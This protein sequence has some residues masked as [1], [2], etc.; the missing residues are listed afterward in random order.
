MSKIAGSFAC[1]KV[2]ARD[3]HVWMT[4]TTHLDELLSTVSD[5]EVLQMQVLA[6]HGA[7]ITLHLRR[8]TCHCFCRTGLH[9]QQQGILVLDS[10]SLPS[11]LYFYVDGILGT[12][13]EAAPASTSAAHACICRKKDQ[14]QNHVT[15]FTKF[16]MITSLCWLSKHQ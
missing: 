1:Q 4:G 9:V 14:V 11:I 7:L 3:M 6:A 12:Y 13:L 2:Q 8:G 15:I 10:D 16:D 5:R